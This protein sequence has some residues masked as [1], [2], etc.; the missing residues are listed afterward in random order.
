VCFPRLIYTP[1]KAQRSKIRISTI[2]KQSLVLLIAVLITAS[3]MSPRTTM[4]QD[5]YAVIQLTDND[6]Y[7]HIGS[8]SP[9]GEHLAF[10]SV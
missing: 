10:S 8:R 5:A 4:A 9:D 7:D 6:T 2:F 1:G 3:S